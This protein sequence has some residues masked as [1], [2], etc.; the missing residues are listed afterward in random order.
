MAVMV[1]FVVVRKISLVDIYQ[2][3]QAIRPV[4]GPKKHFLFQLSEIEVGGG[5]VEE[6]VCVCCLYPFHF[7]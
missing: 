2:Y 1:Y 5:A 7:P 3:L 6:C 4:V